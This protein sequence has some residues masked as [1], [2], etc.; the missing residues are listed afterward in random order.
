MKNF[1]VFVQDYEEND[2]RTHKGMDLSRMRMSEVFE[3]FSLDENTIDF[4]GHALALH[5]D[6]AYLNEAALP[7]IRRIK[8]YAE[9]LTR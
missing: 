7:T 8:L 4:I 6:D 5:R 3:K 2:P 9:S 1:F